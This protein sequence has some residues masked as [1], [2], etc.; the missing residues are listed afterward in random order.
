MNLKEIRQKYPQYND[1]PDSQLADGFYNK[2]YSDMPRADFDKQ[3]GFSS[4]FVD[5]PGT[6]IVD[7]MKRSATDSANTINQGLLNNPQKSAIGG[8]LDT[9]KGLAGAAMA[10]PD[11]L[12][13]APA[14]S[15]LG[16][17]LTAASHEAGKIINPEVAAKD[18]PRQMYEDFRPGV[19]QAMMAAAP[20]AASPVGPRTM[21]APKTSP[22]ELKQ[23][24]VDVWE[25]PDIKAKQVPPEI[26]TNLSNQMQNDLVRRGFRDTPA[27]ASGTLGEVRGLAPPGPK[28]PSQFERLQAEMNWENPIPQ[29]GVSSVS[30][31]DI[32]RQ[33]NPRRGGCD[34]RHARVRQSPRYDFP[35][36]ENGQR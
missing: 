1:L 20:R 26:M 36:T 23:S 19:D 5:A 28:Q 21:P 6:G 14:R 2:F 13:G 33:G 12:L 16:R 34:Q 32:L 9:G 7:E 11:L 30:V 22:G 15:L 3:I 29:G 4:S 27:S 8:L 10:I 25:R 35:G 18:D 24:A 31:D 17:G